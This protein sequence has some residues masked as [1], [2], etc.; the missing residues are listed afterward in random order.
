MALIST[1]RDLHRR[2]ARERRGLALAE[3]VRVVEEMLAAT[4]PCKG[5]IVSPGLS[6]TERGRNLREAIGAAGIPI[7]QLTD[8]ELAD[9]AATEQPQGVIAVYQPPRYPAEAIMPGPGSPVVIL[10][11]VQDPGNVGTIIRTALAFGAAG[12]MALPGT[13]DLHS[14]K[15]VRSSAGAVFRLPLAELQADQLPLWLDRTGASLE[16]TAMDGVPPSGS[17]ERS[18]AVVFGNEGAGVSD[19][20]MGLAQRRLAIPIAAEV[21]SLNVAIA[22]AVILHELTATRRYR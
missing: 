15:V 16:V 2:K 7:E 9:A 19:A 13:V 12:V 21:E 14:P 5:A 4:V 3:G 6:A 18:V 17:V 10:D 20:L 8:H 22:A 1:V 11:A